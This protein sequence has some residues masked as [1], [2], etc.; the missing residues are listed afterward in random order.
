[1]ARLFMYAIVTFFASR[2]ALQ[3]IAYAT[4][5]PET[6]LVASAA[7]WLAIVAF[8]RTYNVGRW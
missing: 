6:D 5:N 3:V 2:I 4:G 8:W 1:M 7:L